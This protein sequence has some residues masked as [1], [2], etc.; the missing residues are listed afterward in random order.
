LAAGQARSSALICP[1][2]SGTT[3]VGTTG[4]PPAPNPEAEEMVPPRF[5]QHHRNMTLNNNDECRAAERKAVGVL[6]SLRIIAH[7]GLVLLRDAQRGQAARE[8][9]RGGVGGSQ[10]TI[11]KPFGRVHRRKI[12]CD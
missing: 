10:R 12:P 7:D 5:Q 2:S 4:Q 1:R 3:A 9:L 8:E 6:Q 11:R